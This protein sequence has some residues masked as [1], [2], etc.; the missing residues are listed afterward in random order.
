MPPLSLSRAAALRR[1]DCLLPLRNEGHRK[2][3][4][5]LP[6]SSFYPHHPLKKSLS[7]FHAVSIKDCSVRSNHEVVELES[8]WG[9][10]LSPTLISLPDQSIL[11]D[12]CCYL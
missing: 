1:V 9:A 8:V 7:V 4:S 11:K 3:V 6:A 12:S 10:V 2:S 5:P